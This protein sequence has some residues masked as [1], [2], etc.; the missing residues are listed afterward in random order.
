MGHCIYTINVCL[1]RKIMNLSLL[2]IFCICVISLKKF[3]SF[4]GPLWLAV[5]TKK[6]KGKMRKR[7]EKKNL[8][9]LLSGAEFV[10]YVRIP[11]ALWSRKQ[12]MTMTPNSRTCLSGNFGWSTAVTGNLARVTRACPNS[13]YYLVAGYPRPVAPSS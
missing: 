5:V 10:R 11:V 13:T 3:K 4:L 8:I 2:N 12:E 1:H 6:K 7:E 9:N